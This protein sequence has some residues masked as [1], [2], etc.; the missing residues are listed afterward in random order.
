MAVKRNF[1]RFLRNFW[2]DW[3]LLYT[4]GLRVDHEKRCTEKDLWRKFV[5]DFSGWKSSGLTRVFELLTYAPLRNFLFYA[6]LLTPS[7]WWIK[8]R[9]ST[10]NSSTVSRLDGRTRYFSIELHQFRESFSF[11]INSENS[12]RSKIP[13][14]R[15]TLSAYLSLRISFISLPFVIS[16]RIYESYRWTKRCIVYSPPSPPLEGVIFALMN[17]F[18]AFEGNGDIWVTPFKCPTL[19]HGFAHKYP[20]TPPFH[21]RFAVINISCNDFCTILS[22]HPVYHSPYIPRNRIE[23]TLGA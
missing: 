1:F 10:L 16:N 7:C 4:N 23:I 20:L 18:V 21:L 6:P 13:N 9:A 17:F 15:R 8:Y 5:V 12:N 3:F 11:S 2:N 14:F 19:R 22:N